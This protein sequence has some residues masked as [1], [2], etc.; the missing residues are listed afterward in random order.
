[1]FKSDP[2][3]SVFSEQ[4]IRELVDVLGGRCEGPEGEYPQ[5][6]HAYMPSIKAA[7]D[8]RS[9]LL[10]VECYEVADGEDATRVVIYET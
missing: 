10:D 1:M 4:A 6:W 3:W 5:R 7:A 9:R 2:Q 8:L